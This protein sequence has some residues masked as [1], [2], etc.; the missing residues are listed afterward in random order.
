MKGD[1]SAEK[2][3]GKCL[4]RNVKGDNRNVKGDVSA[5]M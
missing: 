1:D 2:R 3:E 4:S 5:E